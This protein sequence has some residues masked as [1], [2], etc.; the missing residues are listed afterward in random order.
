MKSYRL[1]QLEDKRGGSNRPYLEFLRSDTLSVG[2]YALRVGDVDHQ[3]PHHQDE[4]YIVMHGRARFTG[5]DETYD[6]S[7]GDVIYVEA[8]LAHRF[9]DITQDLQLVVV[10]APPES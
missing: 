4:V 2:L 10:F 5:G 3:R 7:P 1:A 6:V 8:G 9:H